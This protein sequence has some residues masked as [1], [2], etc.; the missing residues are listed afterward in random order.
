MVNAIQA[1][2]TISQKH[3]KNMI[4]WYGEDSLSWE[5]RMIE[6][7]NAE[8]AMEVPPEI[9]ATILAVHFKERL[10]DILQF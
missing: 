10:E 8:D 3:M 4:R 6:M 2:L 1:E 9:D 7:T 5:R